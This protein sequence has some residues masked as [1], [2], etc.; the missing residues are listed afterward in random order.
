MN[1]PA[2]GLHSTCPQG[3]ASS[4]FRLLLRV[5]VQAGQ[6]GGGALEL[7]AVGGDGVVVG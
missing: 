2:H 4:A 6:V 3:T 5:L 7:S 1:F